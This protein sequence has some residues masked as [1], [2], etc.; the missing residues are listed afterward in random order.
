M[1]T[2]NFLPLPPK[3]CC[4]SPG[5]PHLLPWSTML[6]GALPHLPSYSNSKRKQFQRQQSQS[7]ESSTCSLLVQC[8]P[9]DIMCQATLRLN[10]SSATRNGVHISDPSPWEFRTGRSWAL[11]WPWLMVS[12][13]IVLTSKQDPSPKTLV[14]VPC[15]CDW[16]FKYFLCTVDQICLPDSTFI[17][18][19][20]ITEV[21]IR[22]CLWVCRFSESLRKAIDLIAWRCP[23][24][25]L[26]ILAFLTVNVPAMVTCGH[27]H[28]QGCTCT[29]I[30]INHVSEFEVVFVS[31]IRTIGFHMD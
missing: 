18:T 19:V 3:C 11:G 22:T 5:A 6:P 1:V 20:T 27:S 13:R 9:R 8:S 31:C 28:V 30:G 24:S 15:W 21:Y 29:H 4:F 26:V 23:Q 12:L 10:I 16:F 2:L 25:P 17:D 7:R 14:H